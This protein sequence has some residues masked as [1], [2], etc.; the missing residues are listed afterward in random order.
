MCHSWP[1]PAPHMSNE[2]TFSMEEVVSH[3]WDFTCQAS[4]AEEA[5]A[6]AE[7]HMRSVVQ[8][9]AREKRPPQ[10]KIIRQRI[11]G[12]DLPTRVAKTS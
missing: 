3:R 11:N 12:T 10:R 2:Y 4:T 9:W 6:M 7:H 5:F 1:E 8:Q